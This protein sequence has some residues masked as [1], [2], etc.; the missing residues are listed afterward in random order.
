LPLVFL[1]G[2]FS[3]LTFSFLL[4]GGVDGREMLMEKPFGVETLAFEYFLDH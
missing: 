4:V 1:F 2:F 3:F